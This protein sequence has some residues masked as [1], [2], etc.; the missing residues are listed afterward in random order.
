LGKLNILAIG[1]HPDDIELGCGGTLMRAAR[2]G[3]DVYMYVLT[4][5]GKSGSAEER[6]SELYRSADFIGVNTLWVDDFEDTGLSVNKNLVNHIEYFVHKCHPDIIFTHPLND[7]HHDHRAVAEC[8]L[9]AARNSQNVVAYEI[10]VTKDFTPQLYYD[11]SDVI[12]DKVKLVSVFSSQ[13]GKVFTLAK[14]VRG[15]GEYRALQNRLAAHM[16]H[17]EA[18]Q[19]LKLF[20]NEHFGMKKFARDAIPAA[21]LNDMNKDLKNIVEYRPRVAQE[22]ITRPTSTSSKS[23]QEIV[24]QVVIH[25]SGRDKMMISSSLAR[26]VEGVDRNALEKAIENDLK[27]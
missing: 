14:A 12:D 7:Y 3:H 23:G 13:S 21:V 1:S 20:V 16:T 9:E 8:T 18:F 5:G 25:E 6:T 15:M 4:R 22:Q 26:A 2:S 24:P 17:A 27:L 11:I 19:V 10:P